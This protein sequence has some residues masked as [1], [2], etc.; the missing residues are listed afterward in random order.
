MVDFKYDLIRPIC[1]AAMETIGTTRHSKICTPRSFS[2]MRVSE[3]HTLLADDLRQ[4]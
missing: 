4:N 2:Q 3:I 1:S